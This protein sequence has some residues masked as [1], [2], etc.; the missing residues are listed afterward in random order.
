MGSKGPAICETTGNSRTLMQSLCWTPLLIMLPISVSVFPSVNTNI[1]WHSLLRKGFSCAIRKL[2][3]CYVTRSPNQPLYSLLI[4]I[5]GN[6]LQPP[7]PVYHIGTIILRMCQWIN[8]NLIRPATKLL[9]WSIS[10]SQQARPTTVLIINYQEH[11]L[12]DRPNSCTR[13]HDMK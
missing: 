10:G 11:V 2:P 7:S 6:F 13:I 5:H 3:T 1:C 9:R 8:S 12:N 4:L